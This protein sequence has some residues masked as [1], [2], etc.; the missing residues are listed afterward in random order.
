MA[1]DRQLSKNLDLISDPVI[2]LNQGLLV[3]LNPAALNLLDYDSAHD[4][5]GLSLLDISADLDKSRLKSYL[6]AVSADYPDQPEAKLDISLVR[7]DGGTIPAALSA[8]KMRY[9]G[10]N[11]HLCTIEGTAQAPQPFFGTKLNEDNAEI[12][13]Q[14]GVIIAFTPAFATLL[15]YDNA[16]L[17]DATLLLDITAKQDKPRARE[18]LYPDPRKADTD[19]LANQ[20]LS[21]TGP[22]VDEIPALVTRE[23]VQFNN[24]PALK[25]SFEKYH[26]PT[27]RHRLSGRPWAF[28]I[29]TVCLAFLM[30][31]PAAPL[32]NLNINNVPK[33]YLPPD[34]PAVVID[35][36]VR[37]IFPNDQG[38]VFLFEGVALFSDGFLSALDA[39]TSD[40]E[41]H[42]EV[43]KVYSLTNQDH[44]TGTDEDFWV[45]PLIDLDELADWSE[46]ERRER[47][48]GDRFA[49][50]SLISPDGNAIA[51]IVIPHT[52]D[53]SFGRIALQNDIL[54]L[55]DRRDLTN[56]LSA[57]AGQITTDVAQTLEFLGQMTLFVPL[58]VL[59]GIALIWLLFHRI[60]AVTL[61]LLA[62][63]AVVG[64]SV[65]L[66]PLFGIPFNLIS[67]ILPS[68]LSALTIAALVHLFNALKLASRRGKTG[69]SRIAA[70]LEQVRR[71]AL[72]NALT[73]MAGFASLG[74]SD[75][76][77]IKSLGLTTATGVALIYAVVFHV[78]PPILAHMDKRPWG[79]GGGKPNILDRMVTGTFHI[80]TRY[81]LPTL[82]MGAI[83]I[84]AGTPYLAKIEV[85]TNLLEFFSPGHKVRTDT[86]HLEEKLSGTGSL[87]VVFT[88]D[89]QGGLSNPRYLQMIREFQSWAENRE[90]V[91]KT[92]ALTDFVEEMN[93]GF[94]SQE[95]RHRRIPDNPE[96]ISQYLFVY[97]GTD[98]FDYSD[99][100]FT[101]GRVTLSINVHGAK[102]IQNLM[103][104]IREHL[105]QH[106]QDGLEWEIA[107]LSRMFSDQVD[108]LIDGQ[109]KSLIG[110]LGII[111]LLMF[112]QWRSLKDSVVCM[113]PNLAPV[114]LIFIMMGIFSIWLDVATAMIASVAAG[115]AIDDTIHL[116]HG[117]ISR[118]R[119]GASLATA[120]A[121]TYH[122]AGRAV[123]TTTVILCA[124]FSILVLSDFVPIKHFGLLTSIGMFAALVFDLILFPAILMVAY[125]HVPVVRSF[126]KE[127]GVSSPQPKDLL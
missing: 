117:F 31:A 59:V 40:L 61:S 80:G 72:F 15:G 53:D 9:Q 18:L 57:E 74:L 21:L 93:W 107:G 27:V 116:F 38:M 85:E 84:A 52:L 68:L 39:L 125:R 34:A 37:E 122:H 20:R 60:L 109:I 90:D 17:P 7:A 45:E 87:D 48:T 102:D 36:E 119:R 64:A 89:E 13:V 11:A 88:A 50:R 4:L 19:Q 67:S 96:L 114:L 32:L 127:P 29:A 98:L 126:A 2:I 41:S 79:G 56:Y 71:P 46:A 121:R 118:R 110:A 12:I 104:S 92:T 28:Y 91:D 78:M 105:E 8:S 65:A 101:T 123:M 30:I 42:A 103:A 106:S 23:E 47:A 75:I 115:I 63:W 112:I 14:E 113:F 82:L 3:Y 83:L 51:I 5:E 22:Q 95:S 55:I 24:Q 44:I 76:P 35:E 111:F 100:T 94:H 16:S 81:P 1:T 6:S 25:L 70:A 26:P 33:V 124:Q 73:T 86:E 108:L 58:T 77:P 62:I 43:E 54:E 49:L 120:I 10:E 99:E 66:F 69:K 97:D